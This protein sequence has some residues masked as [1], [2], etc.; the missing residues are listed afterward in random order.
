MTV[1]VCVC[2][3]PPSLLFP[4]TTYICM[5]VHKYNANQKEKLKKIHY[6]L[7]ENGNGWMK[8]PEAR[9]KH[10]STPP[11]TTTAR[12][13]TTKRRKRQ[14]QQNSVDIGK[15][16]KHKN[17]SPTISV[18]DR[19]SSLESTISLL[20]LYFHYYVLYIEYLLYSGDDDELWFLFYI[21]ALAFMPSLSIIY[22]QQFFVSP[23]QLHWL[24]FLAI[25]LPPLVFCLLAVADGCSLL[26]LFSLQPCHSPLKHQPTNQQ[27]I[28]QQVSETI[29]IWE[30]PR[31]R[32]RNVF[33]NNSSK[34]QK[35]T[36]NT[37]K[38]GATSKNKCVAHLLQ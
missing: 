29:I 14:D 32:R 6:I 33:K 1:A 8:E 7:Q 34:F 3:L 26:F 9:R 11:Y 15:F 16:S 36:R 10:Y 4:I 25:I 37:R 30:S 21:F 12:T 17:C 19:S 35:G 38:A 27:A 13:T 5:Y 23:F 28:T 18:V 2:P 24:F 31:S 20:I 22:V